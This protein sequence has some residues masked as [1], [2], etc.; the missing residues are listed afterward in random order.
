MFFKPIHFSGC[1]EVSELENESS[2]AFLPP[3]SSSSISPMSSSA[4]SPRMNNHP[5]AKKRKQRDEVDEA[6]VQLSKSAADRQKMRERREVEKLSATRNPEVNYSLEVAETL[7]RFNPRQRALA[8]FKIQKLLF[9]IE[10]PDDE[11]SNTDVTI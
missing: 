5:P 10:F 7:N 1:Y 9:E 11:F 4:S 3:A 8:K 6:L 2:A